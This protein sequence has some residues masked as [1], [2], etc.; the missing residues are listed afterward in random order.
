MPITLL[1]K[2][3]VKKRQFLSLRFFR[4]N[5]AVSFFGG[6]LIVLSLSFY[7][8]SVAYKGVLTRKLEESSG[9]ILKVQSE[10]D[11]MV[12]E[13]VRDFAV[14]LATIDSLLGNHTYTSRIFAFLEQMTHPT[15]Q[16]KDF[17]YRTQGSTITMNG[18]TANYTTLGEQIIALEQNSNIHNLT[19]SNIQLDKSGR[20]LFGISFEVDEALYR[21]N[22][23]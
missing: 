7:F 14:R 8:G 16:F 9:S 18:A 13:D 20:I 11:S 6:I 3:K 15:V 19:I 5:T 17:T 1:P 10:R 4:E 22:L 21:A 2:K 23:K 12:E